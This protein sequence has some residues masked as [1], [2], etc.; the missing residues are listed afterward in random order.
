ML[1]LSLKAKFDGLGN[2]KKQKKQCDLT[3]NNVIHT[4]EA[5]IS[6]A[7]QHGSNGPLTARRKQLPKQ[8]PDTL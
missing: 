4:F 2:A 1:V 3:D 6:L 5:V 7:L 8:Q